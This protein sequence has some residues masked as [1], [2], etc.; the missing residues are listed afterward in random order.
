MRRAKKQYKTV[1]ACAVLM[2][3]GSGP[4]TA[5]NQFGEILAEIAANN[6]TLQTA[7]LRDRKSVV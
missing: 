6:R 4:V 7:E 2:A 3:Y 5:G 1:L